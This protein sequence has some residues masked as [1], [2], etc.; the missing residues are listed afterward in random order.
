M[1]PKRSYVMYISIAGLTRAMLGLVQPLLSA[2]GGGAG[3]AAPIYLGN[4]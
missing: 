2:G 4:Q 1:C 3:V